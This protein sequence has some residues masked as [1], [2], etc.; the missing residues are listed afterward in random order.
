[1]KLVER[2]K[3]L[4]TSRHLVWGTFVASFAESTVVPVP[5]EAVLIPAMQANRDRL[6]RLATA[7]LLGCIVG[8]LVGYGIGYWLFGAI[9]D[10]L[11]A[12]LGDPEQYRN[13]LLQLRRNGFWFVFSV[14]VTPI[15]FQIAMLAAG[16]A[17]YSLAGY[18]AATLLSRGIRYFGLALLVWKFGDRA[19]ALVQRHRKTSVA[20]ITAI[21]LAAWAIAWATTT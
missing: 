14:G 6:W 8:A 13:A 5:L 1:M 12:A 20:A 2:L 4:I 19:Q 15:P 9:G 16:T 17:H 18:L 3:A 21:V 7:A 11:V 10:Q